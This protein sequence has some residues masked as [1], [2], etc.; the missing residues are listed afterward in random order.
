ILFPAWAACRDAAGLPAS[1]PLPEV[2]AHPAVRERVQGV[3]DSLAGKATG[4]ASR[5]LR[6]VIADQPPSI[7][8]GEIT[9]KGSFNQRIVLEHRAGLVHEL[10]ADPPL[11]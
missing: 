3:I 1:A 2:A 6:A 11:P 10:Y 8:V 9:D 5:V 4:S 7:D